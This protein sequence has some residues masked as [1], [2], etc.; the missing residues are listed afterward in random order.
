[1]SETKTNAEPEEGRKKGRWHRGLGL[2][3]KLLLLTTVFVMIAEVLI[4]VPSIANFRIMWLKDRLA[5]AHTA[6]LVLDAAPSGMVPE[7]LAQQILDSIGAKSV[8]MKTD[9]QR[10]LL[11]T[12]NILRRGRPD[13]R[14]AQHQAAQRDHR[15]VPDVVHEQEQRSGARGRPGAA[16]RPV[17]RD[18][19]RGRA[20][21]RSDA[22]LFAQHPAAVAGDL[23][24]HRG[25]RLPLAAIPVRAADAPH[26]RQHD[27]IPARPGS[28]RPDHRAVAPQ[29]RD[30]GCAARTLR[31]CSTTSS[32]CCT[33]RAA[34][35]RLASRCRRS[36][37]TCATCCRR[38]S[39]S[40]TGS[41]IFPIPRCSNL[42][43]S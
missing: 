4:Y 38:R 27:A 10:R 9:Q 8:V 39:C 14:R 13:R 1:M 20:A 42:P 28:A 34:W 7:S 5:S 37:T 26:H 35:L 30:R 21:A 17:R 2:S 6:A 19:G 23:G 15:G 33:K 3:G 25:A 32:R 18:R 22:R 36:I 12:S 29:R 41:P 31:P 24:D 11:V 40:P 43:P 16:R